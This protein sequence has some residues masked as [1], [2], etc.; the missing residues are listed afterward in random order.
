MLT[1]VFQSHNAKHH[2]VNAAV[3]LE[4]LKQASVHYGDSGWI[5]CDPQ[6]LSRFFEFMSPTEVQ[7]ALHL[8]AGRRVIRLRSELGQCALLSGRND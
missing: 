3:I 2:G 7:E 8:L 6:R 5:D 1:F 4:H